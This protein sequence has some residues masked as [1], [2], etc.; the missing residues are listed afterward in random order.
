MLLKALPDISKWNTSKVQ[1]MEYVFCKC[2]QL[3]SLP[4]ISKWDT[5]KVKSFFSMFNGCKSLKYLPDITKW[6][7]RN[8]KDGDFLL[9][10]H[11]ILIFKQIIFQYFAYPASF[12][13]RI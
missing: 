11:V 1:N 2:E 9:I 6:N 7:T 4:D 8:I 3:L 5:S 10:R 12:G 13:Y